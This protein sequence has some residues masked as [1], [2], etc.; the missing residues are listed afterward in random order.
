MDQFLMLKQHICF[1]YLN[2]LKKDKTWI[3][4]IDFQLCHTI[5]TERHLLSIVF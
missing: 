3:D 1:H 2:I 5:R 4:Q